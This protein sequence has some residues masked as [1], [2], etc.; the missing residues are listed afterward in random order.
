MIWFMQALLLTTVFAACLSGVSAQ[1]DPISITILKVEVQGNYSHLLF[2][3]DNR[4][5]QPFD[6]VRVSCV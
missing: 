2:S 6:R 3:V 4:L 5:D 1:E